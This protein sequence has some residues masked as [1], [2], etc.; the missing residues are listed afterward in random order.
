M[1][2]Q[3]IHFQAILIWRTVPLIFFIANLIL[4]M[5]YFLSFLTVLLISFK[6]NIGKIFA[7]ITFGRL[8]PI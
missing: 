4:N 7:A 1:E 2:M 8:F 5:L 3:F 6:N